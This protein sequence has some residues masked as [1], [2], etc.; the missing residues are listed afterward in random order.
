VK[1]GNKKHNDWGILTGGKKNWDVRGKSKKLRKGQD[2][3][4]PPATLIGTFWGGKKRVSE[5]G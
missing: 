5:G 3:A 2:R 4:L 1:T